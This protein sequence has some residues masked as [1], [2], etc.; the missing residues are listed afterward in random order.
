MPDIVTKEII[1][2]G[3]VVHGFQLFV[4]HLFKDCVFNFPFRVFLDQI[5]HDMR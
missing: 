3:G 1:D 2:K 5:N 4:R